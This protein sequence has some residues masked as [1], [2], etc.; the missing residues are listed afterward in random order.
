MQFSRLGL[1]FPK[2]YWLIVSGI[3]IFNFL[4]NSRVLA[5]SLALEPESDNALSQI[6][7]VSQLSD[8]QPT[9]WAFQ[10][11]QSLV[12]RY[13]CIVGYPNQTYRG[14]RSLTR[15]EFAA[16]LNACLDRVTELINTATSDLVKQE[17]LATL[18]KLQEQFAAELATLRGR[19]ETLEV[20]TATL[21]K[22][23]FSTTTKLTGQVIFAASA[24]G[25]SGDRI[26][27]PQ[28]RTITSSDPSAT[29][30]YRAALD[31][32]TSSVKN[33]N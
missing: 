15:H 28:G 12:E 7:T 17:D 29:A 5:Q 22:Q 24:G 25:F 1:P 11:L 19:V 21:E 18:Q 33:A 3:S 26:R 14:D 9:D 10:A 8:V 32:N 6:T 30:F 16:G 20:R 13:G 27:D 23:A 31:L 2:L 4:P